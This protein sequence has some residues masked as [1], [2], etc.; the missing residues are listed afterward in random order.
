MRKMEMIWI[1]KFGERKQENEM[2]VKDLQ[3][4]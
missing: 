2:C 3:P 4:I 1:A